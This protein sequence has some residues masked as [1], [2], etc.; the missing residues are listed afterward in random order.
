MTGD[1]ARA[2]NTE[3]AGWLVRFRDRD[4]DDVERACSTSAHGLDRESYC[5][6]LAIN[7]RALPLTTARERTGRFPPISVIP[8]VGRPGWALSRPIVPMNERPVAGN[9]KDGVNFRLWVD[10]PRTLCVLAT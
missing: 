8:A 7:T 4:V 6:S 2:I 1:A 3:A 10:L 5:R 9:R